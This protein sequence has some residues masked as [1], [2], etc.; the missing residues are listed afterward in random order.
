MNNYVGVEMKKLSAIIIVSLLLFNIFMLLP[1]P[2]AITTPV[3]AL[4]YGKDTD[5]SMV[6]ASFLGEKKDDQAGWPVTAAGD[7]NGDGLDDILINSPTNDDGGNNAGKVYL[8]LG[9]TSGWVNAVSLSSADASF[10]GEKQ[11]SGL[12]SVAGVGDV[13]GDGYDDILMGAE[14]NDDVASRAGKAYLIFGKASGW[15]KNL[16]ISNADAT[17]LG[18]GQDNAAGSSVAGAGDVNNDGFDDILIGAKWKNKAYLIL[19]KD[20]NWFNNT[21]LSNSNASFTTNIANPTALNVAGAGDVN[22]D[23]YDDILIGDPDNNEGWR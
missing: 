6:D 12:H 7:V 23:G 14:Y 20:K 21:P 3:S 11:G 18:E 1:K 16:C 8:I 15:S 13:N 2:V 5:L 19:G 9:K 10:L 17:F 4:R 22:N